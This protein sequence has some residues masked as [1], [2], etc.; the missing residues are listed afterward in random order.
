MLEVFGAPLT[1]THVRAFVTAGGGLR[2]KNFKPKFA[3]HRLHLVFPIKG[4]E[5]RG[6]VS[7]N[8]K[9]MV[10]FPSASIKFKMLA[11]DVADSGGDTDRIYLEGGDRIYGK[12]CSTIRL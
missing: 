11:I 8:A 12:V 2:M 6:L 4:S 9:K 7:I 1:G 10:Q 5:R 3:S